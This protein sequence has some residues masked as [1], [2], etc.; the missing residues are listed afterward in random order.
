ME[1]QLVGLIFIINLLIYLLFTIS[2]DLITYRES[3][4]HRIRKNIENPNI[5]INLIFTFGTSLLMWL[6]FFLVPIDI[7]FESYL[8]VK[9][10]GLNGLMT[11]IGLF[12]VC[13]GTIIAIW[14]RLSRGTRAISWGVPKS[15]IKKGIYKYIR[16]PL[17]SSYIIYFI[18]FNLVL[19]QLLL[20]IMLIGIYGYYKMSVIEEGILIEEFGDEYSNYMKKTARFFPII[21]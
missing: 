12:L 17:Y 19:Q 16:H 3:S 20:L 13:L 21:W 10:K 6:T 7:W 15:L 2:L 9:S 8:I 4:E 1:T 5:S 11:N 14:G 18:G